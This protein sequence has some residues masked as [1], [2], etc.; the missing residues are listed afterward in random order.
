MNS[1]LDQMSQAT[2]G[3]QSVVDSATQGL[4]AMKQGTQGFSQTLA[5]NPG[6]AGSAQASGNLAN[7]AAGL[8]E[9]ASGQFIDSVDSFTG[10]VDGLGGVTD[11]VGNAF[12]GV[13]EAQGAV[14]EAFSK[15]RDATHA[16]EAL[17][18]DPTAMENPACRSAVQ[19]AKQ[20]TQQ[21]ESKMQTMA[22][23]TLQEVQD[24]KEP[25]NESL[26]TATNDAQD[27]ADQSQ[28][29]VDKTETADNA[30]KKSSDSQKKV[31]DNA[32]KFSGEGI[33][34][35][36]GIMGTYAGLGALAGMLLDGLFEEDDKD[37]CDQ[38]AQN[39][40]IDYFTNL[41]GGDA[42]PLKLDKEGIMPNWDRTKAKVFGNWERQEMGIVFENSSAIAIDEPL[43]STLDLT[44]HQ[45]PH[46]GTVIVQRGEGGLAGIGGMA[47]IGGGAGTEGG[48]PAGGSGDIVG[49]AF[50]GLG[51][52]SPVL[53]K[54]SPAQSSTF[55]FHLKFKTK[56]YAEKAPEIPPESM[57]VQG[58]LI[59][60]TGP[61]GLPKIAFN[62]NWSET[63]GI[64][65]FACDATNEKGIYCDA[66]QFTIAMTK[67]LHALD[68]FL[69]QNRSTLHCPPNP[70]LAQL[71]DMAEP[72]HDVLSDINLPS[73]AM[74]ER[75]ECWVPA[76]TTLFDGK[77]A[78][79]YYVE[80]PTSS[81]QWTTEIPD[82][83]T[84]HK[85]I[86]WK[87]RLVQDGYSPDFLSDFRN[88]YV[89]NAFFNA[90]DYFVIGGPNG[91]L[92]DYFQQPE[93]LFFS[94]RYDAST[95]IPSG[96]TYD[97]LL[98]IDFDDQL[99]LF[100]GGV[101]SAKINAQYYLEQEARP[102][103]AFYSMPLDGPIGRQT[104]NGRQ[105]YAS[106]YSNANDAILLGTFQGERYDTASIAG[107]NALVK[108]KT[109]WNTDP[110][111]LNALA[112]S[113]GALLYIDTTGGENNEKRLVF[114]PNYATPVMLRVKSGPSDEPVKGFFDILRNK[115]PE[116]WGQNAQFWTG[117]GACLDFTGSPAS[118]TY[119]FVPDRKAESTDKANNWQFAYKVEW[120]SAEKGGDTFL[121][122][123][124]FTPADA[125]Y[126]L[127]AGS[128]NLSISSANQAYTQAAALNGIRGMTL[129]D[130][131]SQSGIQ[132]IDE[133]FEL[134]RNRHAC[135]TTNNTTTLFW[136][137]TGE[138]H[139]LGPNSLAKQEQALR[140]GSTCIGP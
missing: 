93:R 15:S 4:D 20:A 34:R 121:K 73:L 25:V 114:S 5:D 70:A 23:E 72:Y 50:G 2:E 124:F 75:E 31:S 41:L 64:T 138:L 81:V 63:E 135:V 40:L 77:P 136:W 102:N 86:T 132:S 128:S 52:F 97:I 66:T 33:A 3:M 53:R 122:T 35:G 16:L 8:G 106:N 101:P 99:T 74:P 28:E 96:G 129:N 62:W 51:N 123:Y 100:S 29:A 120:P 6:N 55:K 14:N 48:A 104:S 60:Q 49:G 92:G 21:L 18:G 88:Y 37:K 24:L 38:R 111:R 27:A 137:N 110:K 82:M 46:P 36:L 32:K 39:T 115:A 1:A 85:T 61:E 98:E 30:N 47:S 9:L 134:V 127:R 43:Y 116:T 89:E 112:S 103:N 57:C 87:A 94:N 71:R 19:A 108:I 65:K 69:Y 105:G 78:L 90:P 125:Q 140:P 26:E 130:Q 133:I 12:D 54:N 80:S 118:Q 139:K 117:A 44:I 59:G 7:T 79:E 113:R 17:E 109:E 10:A 13:G 131:Q 58:T 84:L 126:D 67:R 22:D 119:A 56:E 45:H 83:K 91:R 11:N 42:G 68:E 107:S 95:A 76:S